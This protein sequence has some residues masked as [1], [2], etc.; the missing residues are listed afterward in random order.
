MGIDP[1]RLAEVVVTC[2]GGVRRRGSGYR[3]T[4]T[5]VLT[6]GHVL[7]GAVAVE[8]RFDAGLPS[9]W[10]VQ[11]SAWE[12]FTG[13]DLAVVTWVAADATVVAPVL[14]GAVGDRAAVLDV[15]VAGFP[16]WKL[17]GPGP[18]L[19]REPAHEPGAVAVL[20]NRREG[21]LQITVAPPAPA[22]DPGTSPWEGMSGGP[23]FAGDRLVAVV[24][25]HHPA[26]GANRLTATRLDRLD[27]AQRL[28]IGV[29][30]AG[31]PVDVVPATP[32][33]HVHSAYHEQIR[34]IAPAA[35]LLD[36]AGELD[37][38]TAFCAG[39]ERYLWLQAGPWAGK[40]ALLSTF[41]LHPPAGVQVVSFFV[42]ARLAG[43]TDS[44]AFTEALLEQLSAITG[45]PPPATPSATGRDAHRRRLLASAARQ[46]AADGHR[47]V[48]VVDGIDEDTGTG[49]SS[50]VPSIASRL[51]KHD[52]KVVLAGRPHPPVPADVAADHPL[53]SCRVLRLRPSAWAL[54]V[55]RDAQRELGRLLAAGG[56]RRDVVGLISAS[57]GGL[58]LDD[59]EQLTGRPRFEVRELLGG[60][61][62][63]TVHGR[64]DP[65]TDDPRQVYLFAH[66]TL[67]VEA[68]D[69]F[70][71][72]QLAAYRERLHGWAGHWRAA[73][74]PD[75]SPPYLLRAYFRILRPPG[76]L[77]RMITLATDHARH[78]RMLQWSGGDST[79]LAEITAA[80]EAV[81]RQ[82]DPDPAMMALL[83]VHRDI[84]VHRS[85]SITPELAALWAKLG[86]VRRAEALARSVPQLQRRDEAMRAVAREAAAAGAAEAA[87]G[88]ARSITDPRTRFHA[89]LE[90]ASAASGPLAVSMVDDAERLCRAMT[91]VAERREAN[92]LI[93]RAAAAGGHLTQVISAAHLIGPA[94][95]RIAALSEAVEVAAWSGDL[96]F[97]ERLA[98]SI[99]AL[100]RLALAPGA[101]SAPPERHRAPGRALEPF[102][103]WVPGPGTAAL[104]T[105]LRIAAFTG[106]LD[107]AERLARAVQDPGAADAALLDVV[108]LHAANGTRDSAEAVAGLIRD[109]IAR[110]AA[111]E[112]TDGTGMRIGAVRPELWRWLPSMFPSTRQWFR[113][114]VE[115][116]IAGMIAHPLVRTA[117]IPLGD[118][119]ADVQE[120]QRLVESIRA[121]PALDRVQRIAML[122]F[123]ADYAAGSARA[124][125]GR[126]MAEAQ[127]AERVAPDVAWQSDVLTT[128]VR[129][130]LAAG[131]LGLA[132]HAA[133][134]VADPGRRDAAAVMV[135]RAAADAGDL[136]RLL[137]LADVVGAGH[138]TDPMLS[139]LRDAVARGDTPAAAWF[140]AGLYPLTDDHGGRIEWLC[141]AAGEAAAAGDQETAGTL[142]DAAITMVRAVDDPQRRDWALPAV[143][144]AVLTTGDI[145]LA[146][147]VAGLATHPDRQAAVAADIVRA[148]ARAHDFERA[149]RSAAGIADPYRQAD[150]LAD[151][152]GLLAV[153]EQWDDALAVAHRIRFPI[154]RSTALTGIV[155]AAARARR[156][157]FAAEVA[158]AVPDPD[159]RAWALRCVAMA[160]VPPAAADRPAAAA[161]RFY[162]GRAPA[163]AEPTPAEAE[164]AA[165]GRADPAERAA[166]LLAAALRVTGPH[167]RRLTVEAIRD[168]GGIA[169]L[170]AL[171]AV[172]PAAVRAAAAELVAVLAAG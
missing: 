33:E 108:H 8:V 17:R 21:T 26:E 140:A 90:V 166:A 3:V 31:A 52:V 131:D 73:G 138:A 99:P 71:P 169:L 58:A 85:D 82:A 60:V 119:L 168:G 6:A 54:E 137:A 120:A 164:A 48:L 30:P 145:D 57:G 160:A 29:P 38:L 37:E 23:V 39:D 144:R 80:Q 157:T 93:L 89:V 40:T 100:W 172:H 72:A 134:A 7:A 104:L 110:A 163:A 36:R 102:R 43:E 133:L 9:A 4:G 92:L 109:G 81:L 78:D 69:A 129:A 96:E 125:V 146:E 103:T 63:R 147:R 41:V 2:A 87:A 153:A 126:M 35:G 155:W 45:E 136:P 139:L 24:T 106:D 148:A 101:S 75:D 12:A 114:L 112:A 86:Q 150:A 94:D 49:S 34:D 135:L 62:G 15:Q 97:A 159:Q 59:L 44:T 32:A 22:G 95:A 70:G 161:P 5:G 18:S 130:T 132:T 142:R 171:A 74:W 113:R 1:A 42:T 158:G 46:A 10:T 14:L 67:R 165:R 65:G 124:D 149:E 156:L 91:D 50:A 13:V 51:P 53:R 98:R 79:A 105:V 115:V 162:L 117:D 167:A 128:V 77:P 11:A 83:A 16:R 107:R 66:E 28:R 47:L 151:L 143:V 55:G 64:A 123:L 76:D 84:L 19:H 88:I 141:T 61:F 20:A 154:V 68:E 118:L 121:A 122:G 152:A 27:P 111:R 116:L 56:L 170:E 25:S 127:A